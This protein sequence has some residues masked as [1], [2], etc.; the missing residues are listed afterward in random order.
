MKDLPSGGYIRLMKS[1]L[2]LECNWIMNSWLTFNRCK[3]FFSL[4][5]ISKIS[6]LKD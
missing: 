4:Y 2:K 6:Y 5:A 3:V 1:E